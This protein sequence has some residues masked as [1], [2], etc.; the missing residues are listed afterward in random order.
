LAVVVESKKE[1]PAG[2]PG[3]AMPGGRKQ[4]SF[5]ERKLLL[6]KAGD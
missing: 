4:F 5:T 2:V 1:L 6:L 3:V